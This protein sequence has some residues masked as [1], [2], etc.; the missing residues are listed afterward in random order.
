MKIKILFFS[1]YFLSSL[2]PGQTY[3]FVGH[4]G[5]DSPEV[6]AIQQTGNENVAE[7]RQGITN[8]LTN[9]KVKRVIKQLHIQLISY[10]DLKK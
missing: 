2:Q 7:D 8:T 3:L 6:R 1:L 4:P 10:A 5:T 9:K